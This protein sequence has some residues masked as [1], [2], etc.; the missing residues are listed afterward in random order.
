MAESA[1]ETVDP[2][3]LPQQV[4]W[5]SLTDIQKSLVKEFKDTL[6][7]EIKEGLSD[8]EISRWLIARDFDL[9]ATIEMYRKSMKWRALVGADH[10]LEEFPKSPY[11]EFLTTHYPTNHSDPNCPKVLRCRDGTHCCIESMGILNAEVASLIPPQEIIRYHIWSMEKANKIRNEISLELGSKE[12]QQTFCVEDLTGLSMAHLQLTDLLKTFTSIDNGNYPNTLRKV[13]IVNVPTVFSLIWSAVQYFWDQKQIVKFQFIAAGTDYS[14]TLQKIIPLDHLPKDYS[15]QLDYSLP[16]AVPLPELKEKLIKI[17]YNKNFVV[18]KV[19]R[20]GVLEKEF[21]VEKTGCV[22]HFEFKTIDYDIGFGIKYKATAKDTPQWLHLDLE[23]YNSNV[24][25]VFG[26]FEVTKPGYYVLHWD[27]TFSW[28][29][30]KELHYL[31]EVIP[32]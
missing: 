29:R 18:D 16:K 1:W 9:K 25:P 11:Y 32:L 31:T 28:T 22:F 12:L 26:R 20:A 19:P 3:I 21:F 17:K 5:E 27:N 13:V 4:T 30:E 14:T 24:I 2:S 6:K 23:R 15:G 7:G 8:L 10:I